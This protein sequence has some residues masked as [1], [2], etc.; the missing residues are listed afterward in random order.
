[1]KSSPQMFCTITF[2]RIINACYQYL[3]SLHIYFSCTEKQTG[4]FI[5]QACIHICIVTFDIS[6][7]AGSEG[8]KTRVQ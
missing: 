5:D 2:G 3:G 7:I 4:K 8:S 6:M 1:M